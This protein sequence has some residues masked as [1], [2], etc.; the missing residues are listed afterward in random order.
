MAKKRNITQNQKEKMN[1]NTPVSGKTEMEEKNNENLT[2]ED[3]FE[4]DEDSVNTNECKE[5]F[6]ELFGSEELDEVFE[7]SE[8]EDYRLLMK[9]NELLNENEYRYALRLWLKRVSFAEFCSAIEKRVIGQENLRRVC[10]NIYHYFE[11]VAA[12]RKQSLPFILAAP[13]GSGKSETYRAVRDYLY[14]T[15]RFMP[16]EYSD[17]SALTETGFKGSD[18]QT[19][20]SGIAER[21]KSN[22]IGIVFVDEMD[23]KLLP[24]YTNSGQ[25]ANAAVQHALLSVIEGREVEIKK[26]SG[27]MTVINTENTLFIA[28]GAFDF[29]RKEKEEE[30][31]ISFGKKNEKR[32]HYADI[33]REEM[34]EAGAL[35]E[36]VGRFHTVI[37]YHRLSEEAIRN[38][39]NKNLSELEEEFHVSIV[40]EEN[41]YRAI[42]DKS[43]GK[44]GCRTLKNDLRERIET[45]DMEMKYSGKRPEIV[46]IHL[47]ENGDYRENVESEEIF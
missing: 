42:I 32:E 19:I 1:K 41:V 21:D 31:S 15:M 17:A 5:K 10:Y 35:N 45:Q 23:K 6:D 24:S 9:Q 47:D 46:R 36:F 26:Q 38:I 18:P 2:I 34:L 13:S 12:G 43:N 29:L 4:T 40:A 25:N 20:I 33:T 3:L 8:E 7:E 22:G 37:N 14:Q 39:V 30:K 44:F 16:C 28:M 27:R 11:L